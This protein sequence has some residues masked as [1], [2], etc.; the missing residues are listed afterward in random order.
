MNHSIA[1]V[2]IIYYLPDYS[3]VLNEFI[4]QTSDIPPEFFRVH[5]FL[6]YWRLNIDAVIK[7]V[8]LSYTDPF[9][10]GKIRHIDN[11]LEL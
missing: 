2:N 8:Q 4:W 1:T 9:Y 7:E 5:K 6:N 11:L 3:S 10:P